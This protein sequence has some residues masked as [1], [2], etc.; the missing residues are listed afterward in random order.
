MSDQTNLTNLSGDKKAWP[1]YMTIGNLPSTIRNGAGSMAILLLGLL[2]IPPKLATSSKADK[3]QRLINADTL[4][5]IFELIFA[6]LT[7]AAREG[8]SM[9][10]ADGQIRRCFPIMSGWIAD[11]M[12]NVSLHGIK[13]N[14]CPKCEVPPEELGS[15]ANHH[16]PRDYARYE[17]YECQNPPWIPRPM[18]LLA[19]AT[20]TK[21]MASRG[22]KMFFKDSR[23]FRRLIY[24]SRTCCIPFI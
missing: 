23:E 24:T 13:S 12:E 22:G 14:A 15:G 16:R 18:R 19:L 3:L 11:H 21:P 5:G 10:C 2:P 17:R 4:R 9:D 7:G 20:R 1:V 6:P 8:T